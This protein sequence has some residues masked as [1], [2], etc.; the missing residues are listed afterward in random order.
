MFLATAS[1]RAPSSIQVAGNAL[2]EF[3]EVHHAR[4]VHPITCEACSKESQLEM[5]RFFNSLECIQKLP[6]ARVMISQQKHD[7]WIARDYDLVDLKAS[8]ESNEI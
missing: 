2:F 8:V 3:G 4:V 5:G 7:L 1:R 6:A